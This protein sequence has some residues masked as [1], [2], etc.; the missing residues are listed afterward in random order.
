MD[1]SELNPLNSIPPFTN[2]IA[3]KQRAL[4]FVSVAT[5]AGTALVFAMYGLFFVSRGS[6]YAMAMAAWVPSFVT[7]FSVLYAYKIE[8]AAKENKDVTELFR[9]AKRNSVLIVSLTESVVLIA[10][11]YLVWPH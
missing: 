9:R 7:C 1:L 8:A 2:P 3:N 11:W 5:V 10:G 6:G 4:C